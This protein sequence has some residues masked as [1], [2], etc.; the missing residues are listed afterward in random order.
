MDETRFRD[1]KGES[2]LFSVWNMTLTEFSY[3]KLKKFNR[4]GITNVKVSFAD[5]LYA[6]INFVLLFL[7]RNVKENFG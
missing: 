1:R 5:D 3:W 7:P 2:G 4:K 6:T